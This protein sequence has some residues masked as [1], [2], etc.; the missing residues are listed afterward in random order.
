IDVETALVMAQLE[1]GI[2]HRLFS[3]AEKVA[4]YITQI[5]KSLAEAPSKWEKQ[6]SSFGWYAEGSSTNCVKIDKSGI[7]LSK[8]WIQQLQQFNNAGPEVAQAI[9]REYPSPQAL[10]QAYQHS[11]SEKEASLLLAK[12]AVR[13]GIGPLVSTRC[14]GP[15]LSKKIHLF[16]TTTDPEIN[17]GQ[18]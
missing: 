5:T 12:I 9:A 18:K 2:S 16:L 15:E 1:C 13:R 6:N 8:L 11:P 17:L 3:D 10:I 14:I 4:L 7:G